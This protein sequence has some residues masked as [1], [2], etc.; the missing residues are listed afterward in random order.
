[1]RQVST[2]WKCKLQIA[3][4]FLISD[5]LRYFK[6]KCPCG[7]KWCENPKR[8]TDGKAIK[9]YTKSKRDRSGEN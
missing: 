3:G 1:M 6:F 9:G 2:C 8:G 7:Q 4:D 5:D